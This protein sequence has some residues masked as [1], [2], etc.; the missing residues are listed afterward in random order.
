MQGCTASILKTAMVDVNKAI[1]QHRHDAVF[2]NQ[3]HDEVIIEVRED[4]APE[5]AT[6]VK[7]L[8]EAAGQKFLKI[9]PCKVEGNIKRMWDK[10]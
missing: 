3:V 9:V 5:V 6:Y 1:R 7:P 8:L 2:V 4:Q 10:E